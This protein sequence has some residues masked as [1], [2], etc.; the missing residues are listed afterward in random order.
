MKQHTVRTAKSAENLPREQQLAW[1]IAQVAT[2]RVAVADEAAE[3]IGKEI[4][5]AIRCLRRQYGAVHGGAQRQGP[6]LPWL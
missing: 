4:G 1:K 5:H 2:D 3:M 6:A